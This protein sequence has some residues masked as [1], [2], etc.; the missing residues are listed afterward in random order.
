MTH[1]MVEAATDIHFRSPTGWKTC[2]NPVQEIGDTCGAGPSF[3]F[4]SVSNYWANSTSSCSSGLGLTPPAITTPSVCG[5]GGAMAVNLVGA[6]GGVPFDLVPGSGRTLY[7]QAAVTGSHTLTAGNISG[8]P[9]HPLPRRPVSL[10]NRAPPPRP[11]APRVGAAPWP[12]LRHSECTAVPSPHTAVDLLWRERQRHRQR[13]R[14]GPLRRRRAAG[15]AD[16]LGCR[17][18]GIA[19]HERRRRAL[20]HDVHSHRSGGGPPGAGG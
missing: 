4:G 15:D 11:V 18:R 13:H 1:G 10:H 12:G 5:S 19:L 20:R 16:Q 14:R 7:L 6:T 2:C 3:L 8:L 17:R 9:P